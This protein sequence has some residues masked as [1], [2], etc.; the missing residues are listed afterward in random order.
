MFCTIDNLVDQDFFLTLLTFSHKTCQAL[1]HIHVHKF[2]F[3]S[4]HNWM[5]W[6]D[7]FMLGFA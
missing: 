1:T 4:L 3:T 6:V 5:V 2:I 7:D